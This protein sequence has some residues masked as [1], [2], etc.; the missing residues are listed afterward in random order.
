MNSPSN[1]MNE[2]FIDLFRETVNDVFRYSLARC[3]DWQ[4][5][6]QITRFV[7][8]TAAKLWAQGLNLKIPPKEWLFQLA[9]VAQLHH[10]VFDTTLENASSYPTQ[11]QMG[12]FAQIQENAEEWK[13]LPRKQAD[14]LALTLF[15]SLELDQIA[16]TLGW[17]PFDTQTNLSKLVSNYSPLRSLRNEITPV[18]YFVQH[19]EREVVNLLEQ[20]KPSRALFLQISLWRLEYL[21]E[22]LFGFLSKAIPIIVFVSILFWAILR[23]SSS[24]GPFLPF[25]PAFNSALMEELPPTSTPTRAFEVTSPMIDDKALY[26][27]WDGSIRM[28]N[29]MTEIETILTDPDFY[30]LPERFPAVPLSIS[31]DG[32]WLTLY[33]HNDQSLWLIPTDGSKNTIKVASSQVPFSWSSDSKHLLLGKFHD[34]RTISDFSLEQ[35]N[36][37]PFSKLPGEVL[38]VSVSPNNRWIAVMYLSPSGMPSGEV[39]LG[40]LDRSGKKRVVLT[41]KNDFQ[42]SAA[43]FSG[44]YR[45]LWTEQSD[46]LWVPRWRTAY[47][48]DEVLLAELEPAESDIPVGQFASVSEMPLWSPPAFQ[49]EQDIAKLVALFGNEVYLWPEYSR[50][51][52]RVFLSPNHQKVLILRPIQGESREAYLTLKETNLWDSNVWTNEFPEFDLAYWTADQ[53]YVLL[54]ESSSTPGRIWLLSIEHPQEFEILSNDG[55]LLGTFSF[56][57]WRSKNLASTFPVE[58]IFASNPVQIPAPGVSLG[59]F[60]V[61]VGWQI[62]IYNDPVPT[63]SITNFYP[64]DPIGWIALDPSKVWINIQHGEIL[65]SSMMQSPPPDFQTVSGIPVYHFSARKETDQTLLNDLYWIY[66]KDQG[67]ALSINYQPLNTQQKAWVEKIILSFQIENHPAQLP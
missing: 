1:N 27:G 9:V 36:V 30:P 66:L 59:S 44:D 52:E 4:E 65:I 2:E 23:L 32:N 28:L 37:V 3:G 7:F 55:I 10:P 54:G 24:S 48:I 61:P 63:L 41:S 49:E 33:R 38:S 35:G 47:S 15:T 34:Y 57:Q 42:A 20:K 12:V 45:L 64:T 43:L 11:Q 60:L 31:P 58:A 51:N 29:L 39:Y 25:N 14:G 19:L 50:K 8:L 16:S 56:L 13:R 40:L 62:W 5:A 22:K 6:Q 26:V 18:G 17:Y 21:H 67:T 46:Q 53:N